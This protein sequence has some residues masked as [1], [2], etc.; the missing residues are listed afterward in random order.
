[1]ESFKL[2]LKNPQT[3]A[4]GDNRPSINS[5][6]LEKHLPH[7]TLLAS[8]LK[9]VLNTHSN[10]NSNSNSGSETATTTTTA[11]KVFLVDG[12]LLY[13][14]P[15]ISSLLDIK[16]FLHAPYSTLL[17]RRNARSGYVT[18]EGKY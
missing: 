15:S 6:S 3:E 10:L 9:S 14:D 1:M 11:T 4:L 8:Q 7:L 18:L 12:F 13:H 2:T 17:D 5:D 16:I